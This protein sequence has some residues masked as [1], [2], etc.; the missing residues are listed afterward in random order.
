MKPSA[1]NPTRADLIAGWLTHTM[2]RDHA[3]ATAK[4]LFHLG[5]RLQVVRAL[6]AEARMHNHLLIQF[7]RRI[8]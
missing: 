8:S 5:H 3:I 7:K 4:E 1:I 2:K 6:C